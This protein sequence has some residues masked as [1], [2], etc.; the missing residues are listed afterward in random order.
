MRT[1]HWLALTIAGASLLLALFLAGGDQV[2]WEGVEPGDGATG[3]A[4]QV[5]A[6][7]FS[8]VPEP[9]VVHLEV[10]GPDGRDVVRGTPAVQGDRIVASVD[11]GADGLYQVTYHVELAGAVVTGS[12][13]FSVGAGAA[14]GTEAAGGHAH[15][16]RDPMSAGLLL[17]DLVLVTIVAVL[18]LRRPRL[19]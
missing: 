6:L 3:P 11:A 16:Q 17:L 14:G 10:I 18:I 4:P 19:R 15:L 8:D 7:R 2:R 12:S 1:R 9:G 5:V 13:A